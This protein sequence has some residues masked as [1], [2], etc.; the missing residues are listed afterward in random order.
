MRKKHTP[1]GECCE[2]TSLSV[3][4]YPD[5]Y[6][7][8]RFRGFFRASNRSQYRTR[9]ITKVW[10]YENNVRVSVDESTVD[11]DDEP[12]EIA[13]NGIDN[14]PIACDVSFASETFRTY[15]LG[16]SLPVQ[17]VE[18]NPESPNGNYTVTF[19]S[20]DYFVKTDIEIY[21]KFE[22]LIEHDQPYPINQITVPAATET[23]EPR[24]RIEKIRLK[25][26]KAFTSMATLVTSLPKSFGEPSV[27]GAPSVSELATMRLFDHNEFFPADEEEF[28]E[29][30]DGLPSESILERDFT[31]RR[32]ETDEQFFG[33]MFRTSTPQSAVTI[34]SAVLR[35][36][37]RQLDDVSNDAY[38]HDW[39]EW[40]DRP[41]DGV[42]VYKSKLPKANWELD[43]RNFVAAPMFYD[44]DD[45]AT[46]SIVGDASEY[47]WVLS[48][49]ENN[50]SVVDEAQLETAYARG[51]KI[52]EKDLWKDNERFLL[53]KTY[54]VSNLDGDGDPKTPQQ[55]TAD[56]EAARPDR[57]NEFATL[58]GTTLGP[59][60]RMRPTAIE[61]NTRLDGI[62]IWDWRPQYF[63]SQPSP[64]FELTLTYETEF[65]HAGEIAYT[66][67]QHVADE[68][69][70]S[71]PQRG[72][73][74]IPDYHAQEWNIVEATGWTESEDTDYIQCGTV[75]NR[76][77]EE[78]ATYPYQ[79][80]RT[81][82]TSYV[83]FAEE[84]YTG[85]TSIGQYQHPN[86]FSF[87]DCASDKDY[88]AVPDYFYGVTVTNQTINACEKDGNVSCIKSIEDG[89][90]IACPG[91]AFFRNVFTPSYQFTGTEIR[92]DAVIQEPVFIPDPEIIRI[93]V[94]VVLG[95][96]PHAELISPPADFDTYWELPQ[97]FLFE[98]V[99]DAWEFRGQSKPL[100]LEDNTAATLQEAIEDLPI[101]EFQYRFNGKNY[102]Y[103]AEGSAEINE[104]DIKD[105]VGVQVSATI[106]VYPMYTSAPLSDG[107]EP[108][109]IRQFFGFGETTTSNSASEPINYRDPQPYPY[110]G[111]TNNL[112]STL[113][114]AENTLI[115]SDSG[116]YIDSDA[117]NP[118]A[119][120]CEVV[121]VGVSYYTELTQYPNGDPYPETRETRIDLQYV[122][123]LWDGDMSLVDHAFNDDSQI[124]DYELQFPRV[125]FVL[126]YRPI[127]VERWRGQERPRVTTTGSNLR[128]IDHFAVDDFSI[129]L[130]DFIT[131]N[132]SGVL[133]HPVSFDF[134]TVEV[135][136]E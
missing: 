1:G 51:R 136:I 98:W 31:D 71:C 72:C 119:S 111:V 62:E 36:D 79:T 63:E 49:I 56:E 117:S 85:K 106:S 84:V 118:N 67:L 113:A 127:I 23:D 15:R 9:T 27:T 22:L 19:G 35:F 60:I 103:D 26:A 30:F 116:R 28:D 12:L 16:E 120:V 125:Q 17:R 68:A 40:F 74:L 20:I 10:V 121:D 126:E 87:Q 112:F 133:I 5:I 13:I 93:D 132:N 53:G 44:A 81:G 91:D 100:V 78:E 21:R 7:K 102:Q 105:F 57:W 70:P 90:A 131:I 135:Q 129:P 18:E 48:L 37:D 42:Y 122:S 82:Y 29:R 24:Y 45:T 128:P 66:Q 32:P 123:D 65:P 38:T 54:F 77:L 89:T 59:W 115:R 107:L 96:T 109:L 55:M 3:K 76:F 92:L 104:L 80:E 95:T 41:S 25:A 34:A 110:Q 61:Q 14:K 47:E 101:T 73:L 39:R 43:C 6:T 64:N 86:G 114:V 52:N 83:T 99:N 75:F 69:N 8:P 97:G 134:R 124:D 33:A 130:V 58:S 2:C 108:Y 94:N 4:L 50:V 88:E 11:E 46:V